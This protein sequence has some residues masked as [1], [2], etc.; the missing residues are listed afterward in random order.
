MLNVPYSE[1]AM[2]TITHMHE[3]FREH[4]KQRELAKAKAKD[5][6]VVNADGGDEGEGEDDEDEDYLKEWQD[7][8]VSPHLYS[9]LSKSL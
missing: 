7:P 3:K 9:Y 2:Q 1:S 8:Q 6:P 5:G 4:L